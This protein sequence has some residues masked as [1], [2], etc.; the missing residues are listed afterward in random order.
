MA[1][2]Q[3]LPFL[4]LFV[5]HLPIHF[6]NACIQ[7]HWRLL[8]VSNN[9][10]VSQISIFKISTHWQTFNSNVIIRD[11]RKF[12]IIEVVGQATTCTIFGVVCYTW[13][14][15]LC[16][17]MHPRILRVV[18]LFNNLKSQAKISFPNKYTLT[19]F[20]LKRNHHRPPKVMYYWTTGPSKD[21]YYFESPQILPEYVE[22]ANTTSFQLKRN[23]YRPLKVFFLFSFLRRRGRGMRDEQTSSQN[24][25]YNLHQKKVQDKRHKW[26]DRDREGK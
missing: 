26:P 13:T 22:P 20:Q 11:H 25:N 17:C 8:I 7:D 21:D 16:K 24:E 2:Q 15:S 5:T 3:P 4:V 14:H 18:D 1:K 6:A 9:W 12:C 19:N 10:R 23:H